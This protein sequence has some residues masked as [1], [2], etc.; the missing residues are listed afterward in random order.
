VAELEARVLG[1]KASDYKNV[2][3]IVNDFVAQLAKRPGLDVVQTKMP[4]DLG[5]QDRLSGEVGAATTTKVPKFTVVVS[6][7]VGS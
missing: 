3:A 6:K 2:N 1:A 5:S 4:F 7:K